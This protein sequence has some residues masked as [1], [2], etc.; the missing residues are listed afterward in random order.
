MHSQRLSTPSAS[1][2]EDLAAHLARALYRCARPTDALRIVA[3][4]TRRLQEEVG[5]EPVR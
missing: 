2:S 1:V 4:L 5:A 3:N